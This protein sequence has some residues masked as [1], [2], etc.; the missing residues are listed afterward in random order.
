MYIHDNDIYFGKYSLM[1]IPPSFTFS[2]SMYIATLGNALTYVYPAM[3]YSAIVKKQN[4]KD[5]ALGVMVANM[6]AV[7]GI[8]MG[9]IGMFVIIGFIFI[10]FSVFLCLS[11]VCLIL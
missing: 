3:M 10:Y 8:I 6:T 11:V 4:R 9:I 1:S 5:Q 7:L 2:E